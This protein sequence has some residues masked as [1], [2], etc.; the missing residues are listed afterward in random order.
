[1]ARRPLLLLLAVLLATVPVAGWIHLS[2]EEAGG[3]DLD[4]AVCAQVHSQEVVLHA[5]ADGVA[6]PVPVAYDVRDVSLDPAPRR[7]RSAVRSRA[8]PVELAR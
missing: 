6:S 5:D 7:A 1:M 3:H 2:L 4:C 8:P